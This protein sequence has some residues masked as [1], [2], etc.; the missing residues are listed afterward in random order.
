MGYFL[1][2]YKDGSERLVAVCDRNIIGKSFEY[3]GVTIGVSDKF[4][5]KMDY[6][7]EEVIQEILRSSS[8][9]AMGKDICNLLIKMNLVHP[10]TVIWFDA[11][12]DKIGHV[13]VVG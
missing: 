4:Y 9:N 1:K 10:A 11:D 8:I 5:G 3:N 6:T 2:I 7:E 12:G 13:I